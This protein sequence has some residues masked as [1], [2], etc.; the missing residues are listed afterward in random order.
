MMMVVTVRCT[1]CVCHTLIDG[2]GDAD[3]DSVYAEK[4]KFLF[5]I[6]WTRFG[7][8]SLEKWSQKMVLTMIDGK[9]VEK[10]SEGKWTPL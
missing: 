7:D 9:E 6:G 8:V 2:D 4:K 5:S 1:I 3:E 10:P